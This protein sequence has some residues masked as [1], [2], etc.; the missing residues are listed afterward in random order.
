MQSY[1]IGRMRAKVGGFA[2]TDLVAGWSPE[3]ENKILTKLICCGRVI[4][5]GPDCPSESWP[6]LFHQRSLSDPQNNDP[7]EP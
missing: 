2:M 7:S 4:K 5:S 1:S 6:P 3:S